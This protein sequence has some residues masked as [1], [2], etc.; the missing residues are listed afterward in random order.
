MRLRRGEVETECPK[1]GRLSPVTKGAT[2]VACWRCANGASENLDAER[3]RESAQY[4][5]AATL[6]N[7]GRASRR[8]QKVVAILLKMSPAA[9]TL[10]KQGKRSMPDES[11]NIIKKNYPDCL[12]RKVA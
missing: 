9:L 7:I 12:T 3:S 1:C 2:L 10:V 4:D 8:T 6:K 5:W 11:M